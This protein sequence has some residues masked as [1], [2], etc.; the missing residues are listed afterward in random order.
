MPELPPV[1]RA[2]LADIRYGRYI[3][4]GVFTK[5]QGPQRWDDYYGISTP[6]LSFQMVF[7]HAAP[8]RIAAPRRPGGALVLMS[9][10]SAADELAALSDEEIE[11]RFLRDLLSVF[12]ELDG[13]V[14]H[15]VVKRQPRVVSYWEPGRRTSSQRTLRAPMGAIR[16]AGDYLGDPS[17]AA[18]AA[19]GQRAAEKTLDSM[20]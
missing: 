2:A 9:G 12:P 14:D 1:Q 17:L 19:S 4:A 10:G 18:A 3:L 13:Q 20:A 6:E 15:V 7:N 5:E 16:F 8:L 11:Q